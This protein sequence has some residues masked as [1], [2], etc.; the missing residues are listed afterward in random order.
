MKWLTF[1]FFFFSVNL[2]FAQISVKSVKEITTKNDGEYFYPQFSNDGSKIFFTSVNYTG[3]YYYDFNQNKIKTVTKETG[4]G[5]EYSLTSDDS[6][7]YYRTDNY[8]DG[9][10]Y[11]SIKAVNLRNLEQRLIINNQRNLSTPKVLADGNVAYD[12]DTTLE[13]N[14]SEKN[15]KKSLSQNDLL[16]FIENS[17]IALYNNGNKIILTPAGEGNYIWPSVS[18]DQ[19]ML[20]FTLAG[21]G[22]FISDLDG[23]IISKIGNANAPKWSSDSKWIIYMVDKDNGEYVTSSDIF[24]S[25]VDGNT[26][27]Q[28]TDTKDKIEMY[29]QFN[30]LNNKIVCNTYNGRILLI[31]LNKEL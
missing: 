6:I 8:I 2:L 30:A 15:L 25:S 18:P 3:I 5:Y 14:L 11:S 9:K 27:L 31:E 7:V 22:T 23:N 24:I 4:A 29:P 20:L 1:V 19:S 12:L 28:I 13:S 10:K 16:V 17:K 21:K 26:K